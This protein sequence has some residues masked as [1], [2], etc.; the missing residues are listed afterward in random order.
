MYLLISETRKRT[1]YGFPR[2]TTNPNIIAHLG[3]AKAW[4]AS[5]P[6]DRNSAG[7]RPQVDGL[8]RQWWAPSLRLH[9][10]CYKDGHETRRF[11]Q[12]ALQHYG[13]RWS[14]KPH[15]D[16]GKY[17]AERAVPTRSEQRRS[18]YGKSKA[19]DRNGGHASL[20]PPYAC[21]KMCLEA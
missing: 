21:F 20:C 18:A 14:P 6:R 8:R 17:G 16:W 11:Y 19:C 13:R 5:G 15:C 1:E 2:G 12:S 4:N 7:L 9:Y 3:W 10:A